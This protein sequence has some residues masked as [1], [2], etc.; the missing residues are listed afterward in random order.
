[1][2]DLCLL[3]CTFAIVVLFSARKDLFVTLA[4]KTFYYF[5]DVQ[6]MKGSHF[7]PGTSLNMI[8]LFAKN[9]HVGS[10]A[11]ALYEQ[12]NT[13]LLSHSNA[14]KECFLFP[15]KGFLLSRTLT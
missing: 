12:I 14:H 9:I 4:S 13:V 3:I 8:D 2:Q 7:Q 10:N 6:R 11:F 5:V 15:R 1:M